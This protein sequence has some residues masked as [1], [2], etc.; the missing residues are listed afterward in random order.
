MIGLI[1]AF[2]TKGPDAV[3]I[4]AELGKNGCHVAA[5]D[6]GI[7]EPEATFPIQVHCEE[8]VQPDDLQAIRKNDQANA[9]TAIKKAIKAKIVAIC[10]KHNLAG[11]IGLGGSKGTDIISAAMR[12]APKDL[13]KVLI[14]T[15]AQHEN[16]HYTKVSN[17][18]LINSCVDVGGINSISEGK[19]K[20]AAFLIA[21]LTKRYQTRPQVLELAP[22]RPAIGLSMLGVTTKC[23]QLCSKRLREQQFEPLPFHAVGT[24]GKNLEALVKEGTISGGVMDLTLHEIAAFL[25]KGLFNAGEKRLLAPFKANIPHLLVPGGIDMLIYGSFEE[26]KQAFPTRQLH[27][28]NA[29]LTAIRTNEE[30]NKKIAKAIAEKANVAFLQKSPIAILI[31]AKGFSKFDETLPH[32]H[33]AKANLA[34]IEEIKRLALPELPLK[35]VDASINDESFAEMATDTMLKL[36]HKQKLEWTREGSI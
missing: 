33:N 18:L 1:G 6:I 35:V 2:D 7:F 23:V 11:L 20:E 24:G 29:Q 15:V 9:V 32:W 19:Y 12:R 14:S 13:P 21:C 26:T 25:G 22:K 28:C 30:E 31:P 34:F 16:W 27:R 17:I 4:F 8:L 10:H 3:T 5:I 36:I